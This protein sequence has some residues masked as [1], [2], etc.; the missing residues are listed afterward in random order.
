MTQRRRA[1]P[2]P[3]FVW[4]SDPL[5][6]RCMLADLAAIA[7]TLRTQDSNKCVDSG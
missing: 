5:E 7:E 3:A 6:G 4:Q 1:V 2:E